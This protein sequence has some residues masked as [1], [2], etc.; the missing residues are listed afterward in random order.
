MKKLTFYILMVTAIGTSC[1]HKNPDL[2]NLIN[3]GEFTRA[4][5]L[6][7]YMLKNNVELSDYEIAFLQKQKYDLKAVHYSYRLSYDDMF[8]AVKEEIIDVT[9]E[10]IQDWEKDNSLEYYIIDGEKRYFFNCVFDLLQVNKN[11]AKRAGITD[12]QSGDYDYAKYPMETIRA[13]QKDNNFSKQIYVALSYLQDL[14]HIPRGKILKAWI[15]FIRENAFQTNIHIVEKNIKNVSLP[16]T[17]YPCSMIY[18]EHEVNNDYSSGEEWDRF[19]NNP[20]YD[21]MYSIN[22]PEFVNDSTFLLQ[23]VYSY[24]SRAYYNK[25]VPESLTKYNIDGAD[26]KNYTLETV[27]NRF[28]NYLKDL[29][30]NI[31]GDETNEYQKA[32]LIYEWIC[33]NITWTTPKTIIGDCAEY[34]AR[35]KRGD[36]GSKSQLFISL[37]RINNIPARDQGGWLVRPNRNHAQHT[38]AQIYFEPYGWLPV[39]V[40]F[41]KAL[42]DSEN[43]QLKYFYFGNCTPHHLIIYDD[44]SDI[45]P[46]KKHPSLSGGGSQLGVFQWEKGD[47]EPNIKFDSYVVE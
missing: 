6:I 12:K 45:L 34:T 18:F 33:R 13:T 39:D 40:T 4:E 30:A 24:T 14:D 3:S 43:D 11:A 28:T 9:N 32:K 2:D 41:G 46:K 5:N 31:I 20:E 23:F 25:I 8:E 16:K 35:Y 10:D 42:I 36:C 17:D 47:L 21:W 38:W 15:P 1:H 29:S 44:A 7:D 19:F 27:N 37:C 26:Y 22:K